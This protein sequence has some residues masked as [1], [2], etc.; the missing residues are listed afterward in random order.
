[1]LALEPSAMRSSDSFLSASKLEA[2]GAH[3]AA[4]LNRLVGIDGPDEVYAKIIR[5][6]ADLIPVTS[7]RVDRDIARELLT[8]MMATQR[9][10]ELPAKSL[11][12][13]TLRFLALCVMEADPEAT[14]LLCMEEPENG[15]HPA[16]IEAMVRL[17]RRLAVDPEEE[18]GS[19]NPMRQI[20]VNTHSPLLVQHQLTDRPEDLLLAIQVSARTSD[21][22]KTRLTRFRPLMGTWRT[23][24]DRGVSGIPPGGITAYLRYPDIKQF[25]L[26]HE[27]AQC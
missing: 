5:D 11:S 15:I 8:V 18:P 27:V 10:P 13:G 2:N 24:G 22:V 12:D 9:G 21:G 4:T 6:L 17:V 3:L 25:G 14:G 1:M 26:F 7:L 19:D 20:I 16:R 23:H